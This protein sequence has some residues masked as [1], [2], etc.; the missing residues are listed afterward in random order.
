M[1]SQLRLFTFGVI[2][3]TYLPF[4]HLLH[5]MACAECWG[6]RGETNPVPACC[7]HP[8]LIRPLTLP[9]GLSVPGPVLSSGG[10]TALP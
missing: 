6:H 4:A 2:L 9:N 10:D 3:S 8:Y 1:S 5:T 7:I